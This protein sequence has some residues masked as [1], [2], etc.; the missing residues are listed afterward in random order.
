MRLGVISSWFER[1]F[2]SDLKNISFL[3]FIYLCV[4]GLLSHLPF[5]EE[6]DL[7]A[8]V[9][10]ASIIEQVGSL[11]IVSGMVDMDSIAI[12]QQTGFDFTWK[13]KTDFLWKCHANIIECFFTLN[14]E[15]DLFIN[16]IN[17][18]PYYF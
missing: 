12:Q 14:C 10:C 6:Q 4:F 1:F 9:Y 13:T 15:K 2:Q 5:L 7:D 17:I 3:K 11:W 16:S 18:S 8:D